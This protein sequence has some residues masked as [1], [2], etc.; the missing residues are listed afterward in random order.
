M[1]FASKT[2]HLHDLAL[3]MVEEA[4]A[5]DRMARAP[6]LEAIKKSGGKAGASRT[7][8]VRRVDRDVPELGKSPTA[9][10]SWVLDTGKPQKIKVTSKGEAQTGHK[11]VGR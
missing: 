8:L 10:G 4:K 11:S 5:Y 7:V 1:S 9:Q 6:L 3:A 2:R